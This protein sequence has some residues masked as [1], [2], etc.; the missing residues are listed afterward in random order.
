MQ[1]ASQLRPV[2]AK[3]S[4]LPSYPHEP[5]VARQLRIE[6][7]PIQSDQHRIRSSLHAEGN[8]EEMNC[9]VLGCGSTGRFVFIHCFR[10]GLGDRQ[11]PVRVVVAAEEPLESLES[12]VS[13]SLAT[14]SKAALPRSQVSTVVS[15]KP[16]CRSGGQRKL[17]RASILQRAHPA[18]ADR[19]M[20]LLG[21]LHDG[22]H[23]NVPRSSG[24][25]RL[26]MPS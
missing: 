24:S 12:L 14:D 19:R 21:V 23:R 3:A 8:A 18:V 7:L 11:F 20:W 15:P 17:Q 10:H 25:G 13:G 22:S 6:F 2:E 26:T 9:H 4:S 5:V 16:A 1:L